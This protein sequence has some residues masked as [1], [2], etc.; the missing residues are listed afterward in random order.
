MD[1][2]RRS[3]ARAAGVARRAYE[4]TTNAPSFPD[5]ARDPRRH[6]TERGVSELTIR[7]A[8]PD[9]TEALWRLAALDSSTVPA[10]D[11][12]IGELDGVLAAALS[13]DNGRVIADPFRA[14]EALVQLLVRRAQQLC[15]EPPRT[16]RRV[17]RLP[18]RTRPPRRSPAAGETQT[19]PV[20]AR[21]DALFKRDESAEQPH[22]STRK[23]PRQ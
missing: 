13:I 5:E 4:A 15:G 11:M 20:G 8:Y 9:D 14:T 12:L 17:L 23:E 19:A 10:G 18:R 22:Q 1:K 7:P 21:H 2:I 16:R 6:E 3:E